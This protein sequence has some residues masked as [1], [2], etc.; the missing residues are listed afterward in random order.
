MTPANSKSLHDSTTNN[1]ASTTIE[2]PLLGSVFYMLESAPFHVQR[3][4][5][6]RGYGLAC[7]LAILLTSFGT[8]APLASSPISR[9]PFHRLEAGTVQGGDGLESYSFVLFQ[10]PGDTFEYEAP[11]EQGWSCILPR[12]ARNF[13]ID[14]LH[15]LL[16]MDMAS[17][18]TPT[19]TTCST[20]TSETATIGRKVGEQMPSSTTTSQAFPSKIT[21]SKRPHRPHSRTST[22]TSRVS[23]GKKTES[24]QPLRPQGVTTLQDG[25]LQ[26]HGPFGTRCLNLLWGW[27]LYSDDGRVDRAIRKLRPAVVVGKVEGH[28]RQVLVKAAQLQE[29]QGGLFVLCCNRK[30]RDGL[31]RQLPCGTA[32]D[33]QSGSH[34]I[35]LVVND[36]TLVRLLNN[37]HWDRQPWPSVGDFETLEFSVVM[38]LM[39][40]SSPGFAEHYEHPNMPLLLRMQDQVGASF[41]GLL[42]ASRNFLAFELTSRT[43]FASPSGRSAGFSD[44]S[45]VQWP[46]TRI[47]NQFASS[48]S[49]A[50]T[51]QWPRTRIQNQFASSFPTA[52]TEDETSRLQQDHDRLEDDD[53][54]DE[55]KR[56]LK[57][58]T[59]NPRIA[60]ALKSVDDFRK[61]EPTGKFSLHPHVRREV[62]K[63]HRNL[64]HPA[65]DVFLRA[66]RHAGVKDEILQ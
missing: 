40:L 23:S 58:V 53:A 8:A 13:V 51:V 57:P 7:G 47:P 22:V 14:G 59:E 31:L 5:A 15:T 35:S 20:T 48:F 16:G 12:P 45:S 46:R 27:Y 28:S 39:L 50:T 60:S 24:R 43:G 9:L 52:T 21:E 62:F 38:F 55:V 19:A 30:V 41:D 56:N 3:S 2:T 4:F 10:M 33:L 36:K 64:N 42:K 26:A 17:T 32:V 25:D 44:R 37:L 49:T 61:H 54:F 34:Q 65:K 29:R 11:G 63:V 18:K 66:L 1:H 6:K